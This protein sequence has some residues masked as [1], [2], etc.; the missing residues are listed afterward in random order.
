MLMQNTIVYILLCFGSLQYFSLVALQDQHW[1]AQMYYK[2]ILTVFLYIYNA[3][4]I[5]A[6]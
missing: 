2:E 5:Q 1:T 4:Y 3:F 6:S